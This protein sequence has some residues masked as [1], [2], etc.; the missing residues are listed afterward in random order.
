MASLARELKQPW[1]YHVESQSDVRVKFTHVKR[2]RC[3]LCGVMC[4]IALCAVQFLHFLVFSLLGIPRQGPGR[5]CAISRTGRPRA[6]RSTHGSRRTDDKNN[7]R[8]V[9][10]MDRTAQHTR[11]RRNRFGQE[12]LMLI[13]CKSSR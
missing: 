6:G 2:P 13:D 4:G 11:A 9:W 12:F 8:F 3:R 10:T 5:A 1:F 7:D